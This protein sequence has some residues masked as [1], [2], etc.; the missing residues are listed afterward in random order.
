MHKQAEWR[1]GGSIGQCFETYMVQKL[2]SCVFG[3][4]FE[5]VP[6]SVMGLTYYVSRD[7]HHHFM[8]KLHS[9]LDSRNFI[10][11]DALTYMK[12]QRKNLMLKKATNYFCMRRLSHE[13]NKEWTISF[14]K[15]IGVEYSLSPFMP[16]ATH[17]VYTM[18]YLLIYQQI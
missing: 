5:E 16:R 4:R 12:L 10:A 1:W 14:S 7:R 9:I 15:N 2:L 6:F 17:M 18:A 8:T 11:L 3:C 13:N